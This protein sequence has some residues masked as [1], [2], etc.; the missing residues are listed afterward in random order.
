MYITSYILPWVHARLI[1]LNLNSPY[2]RNCDHRGSV[3]SV[4]NVQKAD[5]ILIIE[6]PSSEFV[7]SPLIP[8]QAGE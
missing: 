1:A 2:G 4:N 3:L 7:S 6:S 5:M 8:I